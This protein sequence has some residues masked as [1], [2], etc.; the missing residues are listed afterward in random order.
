M[1]TRA[2]IPYLACLLLSLSLSGCIVVDIDRTGGGKPPK[3]HRSKESKPK[4][5]RGA[6]RLADFTNLVLSGEGQ[7]TYK[8]SHSAPTITVKRRKGRAD[9][10]TYTVSGGSLMLNAAPGTHITICSPSL[11]NMVLS[12]DGSFSCGSVLSANNI[13]IVVSDRR[14]VSFSGTLKAGTLNVVSS[15]E[16]DVRLSGI[17]CK[18]LTAESS[19]VGTLEFSNVSATEFTVTASEVGDIQMNK[20][21]S[22]ALTALSQGRGSINGRGLRIHRLSATT[23]GEGS[24][25]LQGRAENASYEVLGGDSAGNAGGIRASGMLAE[26]V[27]AKVESSADIHCYAAYSLQSTGSGSGTV[28]CKGN[29]N[30]TY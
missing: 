10:T 18:A 20:T 26:R 29:P 24:I 21:A 1:R 8:R 15:S 16:G 23:E 7:V 12:G 17:S 9:E 4:R 3:L 22:E 5:Q 19:S 11:R 28:K 27:T 30:K 6:I 2:I 25:S 14:S 13:S